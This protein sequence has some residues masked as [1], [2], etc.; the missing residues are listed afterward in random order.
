MPSINK[1]ILIG[2]AG[3]DPELR[4]TAGGT[5][6]ATVSV[7]TTDRWK[8]P[9]SDERRERTEW[10]RIVAWGRQAELLGE[11]LAKGALVYVE[12]SLQTREWTDREGGKRTTTEIRARRVLVLGQRSHD[13]SARE[14]QTVPRDEVPI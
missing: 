3:R 11:Y 1:V 5:P 4:Y 7:A 10:H 6:V 9:Q 8:D 12:G 13:G 14:A 2:H